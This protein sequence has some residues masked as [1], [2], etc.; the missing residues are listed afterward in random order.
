MPLPRT[1]VVAGDG[2]ATGEFDGK[3]FIYASVVDWAYTGAGANVITPDGVLTVVD[4]FF[5]NR[6]PLH[7]CSGVQNI[8]GWV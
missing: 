5:G 7:D 3:E 4:I 8:N 1:N 2:R 6:L